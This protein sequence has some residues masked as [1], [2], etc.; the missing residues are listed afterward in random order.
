MMTEKQECFNKYPLYLEGS[1]SY[2][3]HIPEDSAKQETFK[4]NVKL[5][6]GVTCSQ[7]VIQWI[8]YAGNTWD[9]CEDGKGQVGCGK[10]ETFRN[11]A[12][13]AIIT[14]TGG[15]GPSG[16]VPAAPT[17]LNDNIY[18][19]KILKTN[20][21]T[22]SVEEQALVVRSQVCLAK[23]KYKDKNFDGWCMAN[24]L[25]YPPTCPE[26]VCQCLT[27]CVPTGEFANEDGAD[28]FCHINCLRYPPNEKCRK[29][30]KCT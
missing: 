6:D 30:C 14:N 9:I 10:Q 4:Y 1:D 17:S 25:K 12:D 7:C 13:V 22:N 15:F 26:D 3:F 23:G 18:A 8:Y 20:S 24:C 16:F 2:R 11:C 29:A 21:T 28:V 27:D 5:P 19:I